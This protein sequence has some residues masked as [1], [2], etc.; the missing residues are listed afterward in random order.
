M[1]VDDRL[2]NLKEGLMHKNEKYIKKCTGLFQ[3]FGN[4]YTYDERMR[5]DGEAR[6]AER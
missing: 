6:N 1:G 4:C 2:N 5:T 3:P